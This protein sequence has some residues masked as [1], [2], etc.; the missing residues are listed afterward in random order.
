MARLVASQSGRDVACELQEHRQP[1][2]VFLRRANARAIFARDVA[3]SSVSRCPVTL[4]KSALEL[5]PHWRDPFGH[6]CQRKFA[7]AGARL[8]CSLA[9]VIQQEAAE[10]GHCK[11][12]VLRTRFGSVAF[13]KFWSIPA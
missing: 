13:D 7:F 4:A 8:L 12:D 11:A 2:G 1:I 10:P 6:T 5:V 3:P 9:D